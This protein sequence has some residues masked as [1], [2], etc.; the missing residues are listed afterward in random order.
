MYIYVY[1]Q[2]ELNYLGPDDLE[3]QKGPEIRFKTDHTVQYGQFDD[4]T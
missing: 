2:T 3:I 4:T 1:T